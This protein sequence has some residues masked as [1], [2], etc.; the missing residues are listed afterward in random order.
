MRIAFAPPH[1]APPPVPPVEGPRELAETLQEIIGRRKGDPHNARSLRQ[2]EA[3][4]VY[5]E[6]TRIPVNHE[7][8][9]DPSQDSETEL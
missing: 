5:V 3:K 7:S 1:G 2:P 6:V 8:D 9:T 4:K